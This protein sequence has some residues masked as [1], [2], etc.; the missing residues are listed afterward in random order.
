M[1][2][3]KLK[4]GLS[5]GSEFVSDEGD[6]F[7]TDDNGTDDDELLFQVEPNFRCHLAGTG[8]LLVHKHKDA[9]YFHQPNELNFWVPLTPTFGT[10]TLWAE[11]TPGAQDFS[12]FETNGAGEAV[13]FWGGQCSHYTVPNDTSTTRVSI[14]FRVIPNPKRFYCDRY[15][16][17]HRSD[18]LM[19]FG[20]GAYFHRLS[21]SSSA[22]EA[23]ILDRK[24]SADSIS[25]NTSAGGTSADGASID[26]TARGASADS[27]ARGVSASGASADMIKC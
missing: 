17:S 14:D 15:E 18:G 9:D 11:S 7:I 1:L 16:K 3:A 5:A 20:E 27:S 10:N 22:V 8:H 23:P 2:V 13:Q 21:S 4:Q 19:R 6:D 24:P 25:A 12:P 26:A